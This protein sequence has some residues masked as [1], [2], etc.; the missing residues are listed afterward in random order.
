MD[1]DADGHIEAWLNIVAAFNASGDL[2]PLMDLLADDC[3]MDFPGA[4]AQ[5]KG[6]IRARLEANREA[7]WYAYHPVSLAAHGAFLVAVSRNALRDGST[8]TVGT[9]FRFNDEGKIVECRQMSTR[10]TT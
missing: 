2:G 10:P 8:F 7:G 9:V 1:I 4:P 6:E 5:P 3:T